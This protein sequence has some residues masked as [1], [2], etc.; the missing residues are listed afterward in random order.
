[1]FSKC[2]YM[3]L[4]TLNFDLWSCSLLQLERTKVMIN[5]TFKLFTL[6]KL[7][8]EMIYEAWNNIEKVGL[9]VKILR[10]QVLIYTGSLLLRII[11]ITMNL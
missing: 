2:A 1:M 9:I 11:I 7:G 8:Y 6:S 3:C 4:F 5:I 10:E